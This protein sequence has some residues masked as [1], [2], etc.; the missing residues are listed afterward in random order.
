[1]TD[2]V[3]NTTTNVSGSA[4]SRPDRALALH[5]AT[6]CEQGKGN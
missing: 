2:S 1:M 6:H 4:E 5:P 3:G